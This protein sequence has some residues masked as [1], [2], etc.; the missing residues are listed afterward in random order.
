MNRLKLCAIVFF[1]V[2]GITFCCGGLIVGIGELGFDVF[3]ARAVTDNF[4][5]TYIPTVG[6]LSPP[7]VLR[8][9]ALALGAFFL[10]VVAIIGGRT[11]LIVLEGFLTPSALLNLLHVSALT[12]VGLRVTLSV[13]VLAVMM[14][15]GLLVKPKW[16]DVKRGKFPDEWYGALGI[17]LLG[18]GHI[19]GLSH[20]H[21]LGTLSLCWYSWLGWITGALPGET[22]ID[23]RTRQWISMFWLVLNAAFLVFSVLEAWLQTFGS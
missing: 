19:S 5:H 3:G 17:E 15:A 22:P 23:T 8:T 9:L 11:L 16:V 21:A 14:K 20:F 7:L 4:A 2:L 18:V 6:S 1:A 12:M 10:L 13:L